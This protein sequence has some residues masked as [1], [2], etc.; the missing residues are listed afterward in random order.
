MPRSSR[1]SPFKSSRK[2]LYLLFFPHVCSSCLLCTCSDHFFVHDI[3]VLTASM[4]TT[5]CDSCNCI[6]SCNF[7][8][9]C[10]CLFEIFFQQFV[11][12]HYKSMFLLG[13]TKFHMHLKCG[14][15]LSF[16]YFNLLEKLSAFHECSVLY[17]FLN[18]LAVH[19]SCFKVL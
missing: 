3:I 10:F 12:K 4:K 17:G 6:I 9:L 1:S 5:N 7:M 8:S 18:Y 13:D 16:Q 14:V 11:L 19:F 15:E 2:M